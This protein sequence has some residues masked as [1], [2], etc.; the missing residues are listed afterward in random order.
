MWDGWFGCDAHYEITQS[1]PYDSNNSIDLG[2][3]LLEA[4]NNAT[5][6][7]SFGFSS[8]IALSISVILKSGVHPSAVF[9]YTRIKIYLLLNIRT[10]LQ[11]FFKQ[12]FN[13][14]NVTKD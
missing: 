7:L 3:Y 9:S 4:A 14:S 13:T 5:P 10:K 2:F 11:P 12:F 8:E 1:T 6:L